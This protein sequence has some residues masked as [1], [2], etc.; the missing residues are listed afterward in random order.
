MI[1][2]GLDDAITSQIY[3]HIF[4]NDDHEVGGVL[5]GTLGD[6]ALPT[7]TGAI[8]ALEARGE[9]AS[10]TFTHDAW[11]TVHSTLERDF[12]DK[13]I[14]GWYHS[15]PG[16]GIFLS[17][18]DLFIHENFFSD[19]RQVAYVVDPQ[20]GTEGV[21]IWRDGRVTELAVGNTTRPGTGLQRREWVPPPAEPAMP[22]AP[23]QPYAPLAA[24]ERVTLRSSVPPSPPPPPRASPAPSPPSW[25]PP[26]VSAPPNPT[27][28]WSPS[29]SPA[30]TPAP[31][32][33]ELSFP[34]EPQ[35]RQPATA[36]PRFVRQAVLVAAVLGA[37]CGA[38]T[39]LLVG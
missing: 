37:I 2:P 5:V 8:A 15:H 14:V 34:P 26:P 38:M 17:R 18:H 36:D 24:D 10:V 19:P 25:T 9:R 1:V 7:V 32:R 28:S 6:K 30:P 11:A 16:F 27:I 21:F 33:H 3:D 29:A 39:Q 22:V 12:P 13:Q 20:A 4:V 35:P 23:A 31:S